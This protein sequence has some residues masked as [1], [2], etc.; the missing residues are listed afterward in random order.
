MT[1]FR[2]RRE[3]EGLSSQLPPQARN[4]MDGGPLPVQVTRVVEAG[5]K[6]RSKLRM[7]HRGLPIGCFA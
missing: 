2:Q 1:A 7:G 4:A 3:P 5:G 6:V